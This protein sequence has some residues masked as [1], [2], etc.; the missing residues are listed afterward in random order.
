MRDAAYEG[1][2]YRRRRA[3]HGRVGATIEAAAG[4]NLDEVVGLLALHYHEAQRWDKAWLSR[5]RLGIVPSASTPMWR[6]PASTR[7]R[8]TP[9]GTFGR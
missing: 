7:W 8:S 1:L 4:E 2:P 3:L 9:V 5:E 6:R